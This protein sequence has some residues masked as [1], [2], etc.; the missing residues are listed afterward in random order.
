MQDEYKNFMTY[1]YKEIHTDESRMSFM[2]DCY[3]NFGWRLDE[4]VHELKGKAGDLPN[5]LHMKRDRKIINKTELTRLQR[6]F[7]AC[8][9]EIGQLEKRKKSLAD[10]YAI[11]VG[12]LGT[13]FMA[14]S[15]F[16]ITAQTPH[17]LLCIILSIPGFIGWILP[18]FL[19]RYVMQRQTEKLTPMIEEKYE[20][21]YTL[22][23]K[24]NKLL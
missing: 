19:H 23:E 1:E 2:L 22:C 7:E 11:I 6:N 14:L 12:V 9:A 16:A 17:V 4:N 3:E 20:E 15:T 8:I 21:I 24:G 18:V 10:M 5:V 13:A